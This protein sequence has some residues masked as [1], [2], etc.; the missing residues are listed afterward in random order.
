MEL[1][2]YRGKSIESL[3]KTELLEAL[4]DMYRYYESRLEGKDD[5]IRLH[6]EG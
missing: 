3:S 2:T 4:E 5:I 6:K 1:A